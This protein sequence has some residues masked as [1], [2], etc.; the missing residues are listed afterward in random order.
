[1]AKQSLPIRAESDSRFYRRFILMGLG[2]LAFA[3]WCVYD[4]AIVWPKK[5][6]IW[7]AY[8]EI[9]EE[10]R[11]EL[12]PDVAADHGWSDKKP[13]KKYDKTDADMQM[14]FIMAVPISLVGLWF[15]FG[16]V[17]ARGAWIE[18]TE[19]GVTSSWGQ[20]FAWGDVTQLDKNKW[21]NKGIA[22]VRYTSG[23]SSKS[24]VI[25]DFKFLR[26]PTDA[27]L[28]ELEARLE[29]EMIVNGPTEAEV[30]AAEEAMAGDPG[31][32]A[33]ESEE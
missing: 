8:Q 5:A 28:G 21:R 22:K 31:E 30:R 14:Q 24:F 7:A 9:P 23:T 32:T 20:G 29:R 15:L 3:S 13:N 27:I 26:Q 1:M 16:V 25:D 19:E 12:W 4:G 18:A 11:A 17:R 33:D 2:A 10:D 6:K